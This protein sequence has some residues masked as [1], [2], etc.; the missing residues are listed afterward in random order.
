MSYWLVGE[1]KYDD[2]LRKNAIIRCK[3]KKKGGGEEEIFSL[4][5]RV[6]HLFLFSSTGVIKLCFYGHF[7]ALGQGISKLF[8]FFFS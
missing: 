5:I 4:Y 8:Y 1:K 2:I 6:R 3:R 7:V